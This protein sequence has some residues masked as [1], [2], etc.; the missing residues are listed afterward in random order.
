VKNKLCEKGLVFGI[1]LLFV[2]LCVI[3][4]NA[5]VDKNS[6]H[7]TY[8]QIY[9]NDYTN[10]LGDIYFNF[11]RVSVDIGFKD[12]EEADYIFPVI[13]GNYTFNF[14]V[15][16]NITMQQK[17]LIPRG[18]FTNAK[19]LVGDIPVWTAFGI[20]FGRGDFILPWTIRDIERDFN[21][22]PINGQENVTLT[23]ILKARGFPFGFLKPKETSFE[24]TAHFVDE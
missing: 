5:G 24:V 22:P 6:K 17:F 3:P 1:I 23:I 7:S 12:P 14:T 21:E 4:S 19:I 2:G 11:S 8:S 16:I 9:S 18:A 10:Y 13:D 15:E 20:N